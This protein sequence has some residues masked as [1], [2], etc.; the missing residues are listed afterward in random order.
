MT[1][2]IHSTTL[3]TI[4]LNEDTTGLKL[5][6]SHVHVWSI[7]FPKHF[8]EL[9][10]S[11]RYLIG[12]DE[13][14]RAKRL[15]WADDFKRYLTGRIVLRILLG[16]Y[17]ALHPSEILFGSDNGKFCSMNIPLK[18]NLSYS[19]KHIFI[20]FG[21]CETGI[22]IELIKHDF[23]LRDILESC[24]SPLEIANIDLN[25][26]TSADR[27]FL[28]WTRKEALLKYT[29]QGIIDDLTIIPSMDGLH[30]AVSSKLKIKSNLNLISFKPHYGLVGSLAYPTSITNVEFLKW[31][32]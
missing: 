22:D 30:N 21:H 17:L 26:E 2:T 25:A 4:D 8:H 5:D 1:P 9:F 7:E 10:K 31:Q 24:F 6:S 20:S 18:F 15:H 3:A 11:Y 19:H 32:S 12:H 14:D 13:F 23:A 16:R 28:Q 29:G 27:F